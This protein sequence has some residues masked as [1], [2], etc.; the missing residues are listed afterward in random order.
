MALAPAL[1]VEI[2]LCRSLAPFEFSDLYRSCVVRSITRVVIICVISIFSCAP[3][4]AVR[5]VPWV[6]D[7][8][9][10]SAVKCVRVVRPA[11]CGVAYQCL[12]C[13]PHSAVLWCRV[14]VVSCVLRSAVLPAA[15]VQG[16][17]EGT[18][19]FPIRLTPIWRRPASRCRLV[20]SC[21]CF[22]GRCLSGY[23]RRGTC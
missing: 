14:R 7:A 8:V 12:V 17:C 10:H 19:A 23:W 22:A 2:R 18:A 20:L 9:P 5:C 1:D 4:Y 21:C 11:F 15:Q 3:A 13:L 16:G 6:L